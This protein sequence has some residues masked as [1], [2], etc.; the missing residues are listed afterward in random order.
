M[1]PHPSGCGEQLVGGV[2]FLI[3]VVL[4]GPVGIPVGIILMMVI[5]FGSEKGMCQGKP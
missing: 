1:R 2:V 5:G 4:L 3:C